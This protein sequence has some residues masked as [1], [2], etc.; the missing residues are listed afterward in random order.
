MITGVEPRD[1]FGAEQA[2]W[3]AGGKRVLLDGTVDRGLPL[4]GTVAG[5]V[6]LRPPPRCPRGNSWV[7]TGLGRVFGD[8]LGCRGATRSGPS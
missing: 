7:D 3:P 6:T 2:C 1:G 5:G 4:E 8:V